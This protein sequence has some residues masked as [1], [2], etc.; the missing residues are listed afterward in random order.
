[1]EYRILGPLEVWH[2]GRSLPLGGPRARATLAVLLLSPGKVVPADRI[3]DGVWGSRPPASAVAKLHGYISDLRR[4]FREYAGVT[5]QIVTRRPG[6]L[7][8]PALGA[9][10]AEVFARHVVA[11]EVALAAG[12]AAVAADRYR[13]A[14][15][16][17]RGPAPLEGLAAPLLPGAVQRLAEQRLAAYEGLSAAVLAQGVPAQLVALAPRLEQLVRDYPLRERLRGHLMLALYRIG[18]PD[19]ALEWYRAGRELFAEELGVEP[20]AGLQE[21]ARAI[22]SGQRADTI[23]VVGIATGTRDSSPAAV[24]TTLPVPAQLP[25]DIA[26]FAGRE[27]LADRIAAGLGRATGG[28]A[29]AQVVAI[30]GPG[31]VGKTTLAVHL[32]HLV[33]DR[34][35]DGQLYVNLRGGRSAP[36]SPDDVLGR[37]LRALGVPASA[38]PAGTAGKMQRYRQLTAGRALLVLLD[39]AVDAE[40]V[41]PLIPGTAASTV[42]LTSRA[43]L[44]GVPGAEPFELERLDDEQGL[45]MLERI[46]GPDRV[47][48]EPAAA[49]EIVTCCDRLP[50]AIRIAAARLAVRPSWRL[51]DLASRLRAGQ[52]RLDELAVGDLAVRGSLD[53]GYRELEPSVQR[54]FRLLGVLEAVDFPAW[55]VAA[56]VGVPGDTAGPELLGQLV[57]ARLVDKQGVDVAGQPRYHLH[58]LVRLYAREL[59]LA[60]EPAAEMAAAV[61]RALGGWLWLAA[62]A[63]S[64][65]PTRGGSGRTPDAPDWPVSELEPV[66]TSAPAAWFEAERQALVAAVGQAVAVGRADLAR[67]LAS[68]MA[69]FCKLR[70]YYEAWGDTHRIALAAAEQ[71]GDLRGQ[72]Y[73]LHGLAQLTA[74]RDEFG[75]AAGYAEQALAVFERLRDPVGLAHAQVIRGYLYRIGGQLT[76]AFAMYSAALAAFEAGDERDG[77]ATARYGLAIAYREHGD[78]TAAAAHLHR[79]LADFRAVGDRRA[80]GQVLRSLAILDLRAD[81]PERAEP[82]LRAAQAIVTELGDPLGRAFCAQTLGEVYLRTGRTG[83]ARAALAGASAWFERSGER[84]GSAA[85]RRALAELDLAEGNPGAAVTG[86]LRAVEIWQELGVQAELQRTLELLAVAREQDR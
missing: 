83:E 22:G 80:E 55:V 19:G 75:D 47:S 38:V 53:I 70:G 54:A 58:D 29:G 13:A 30:L 4:A 37:F 1:M 69:G 35:P 82:R 78:V 36:L 17:W 8:R 21:L 16:L 79:A 33:A 60:T 42:I 25:P 52:E 86:L 9:L 15:E 73:L 48:G 50:L 51:A 31:G 71:G 28:T 10:D 23:P 24:P 44:I 72:A 2:D 39:D 56:L 12:D 41:R 6:Y 32:A 65:L 43:L 45:H 85:C 57:A 46:V 74:D 20:A 49:A 59:A 76:E 27:A 14:V 67:D 63:S 66:V 64:R 3:I 40:Q 81:R 77:S 7:I 18:Q 11:A 62:R 68:S 34:Y 84:F 26:D 61:Q 5:D